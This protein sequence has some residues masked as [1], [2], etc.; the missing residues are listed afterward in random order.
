MFNK[1]EQAEAWFQ[2]VHTNAYMHH[3]ANIKEYLQLDI[4]EQ[5]PLTSFHIPMSQVSRWNN[6]FIKTRDCLFGQSGHLKKGWSIIVDVKARDE[7]GVLFL[8]MGISSCKSIIILDDA[9]NHGQ[10]LD[11]ISAPVWVVHCGGIDCENMMVV[12]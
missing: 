7:G 6:N 12:N 10:H 11:A 9:E 4:M 2:T 1:C 3:T 5:W 8:L